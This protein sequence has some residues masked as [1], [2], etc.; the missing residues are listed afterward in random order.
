MSAI[1]GIYSPLET[2]RASHELLEKMLRKLRHRGGGDW[3]YVEE[4]S[5]FA[6]AANFS[7]AASVRRELPNW[8]EDSEYV[9]ALD[10]HIYNWRSLL[11]DG[12]SSYNPASTAVALMRD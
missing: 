10:G 7:T 12:T 6:I 4:K 5:G 11:N 8:Y 9:A 1:C 3:Q 2:R